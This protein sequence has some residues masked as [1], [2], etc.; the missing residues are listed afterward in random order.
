MPVFF[1][2]VPN[3][4]RLKFVRNNMKTLSITLVL[5]A[6]L[7]VGCKKFRVSLENDSNIVGQYEWVHSYGSN[8]DSESFQTVSDKYGIVLKKNGN[9]EFYKNGESVSKGYVV[10]ITHV[11]SGRQ[12]LKLIMNDLDVYLT[13]E[14]DQLERDSYPIDN[15]MNVFQKL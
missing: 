8:N 12:R 9:A 2:L 13:Y 5:S 4:Q 11:S 1:M 6:L 3:E 7:F 14:N 15:Q 10:E